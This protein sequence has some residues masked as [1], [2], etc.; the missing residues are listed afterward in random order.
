M[1]EKR[2]KAKRLIKALY[3]IDEAYYVSEKKKR[4]S[5]AEL[6]ILYALD[7]DLPH[8]QNEISK[9]WLISKSTINTITKKW[10]A[11]EILKL[12]PIENKRREMHIVLTEKGKEYA[13]KLLPFI[14]KA[15]DYALNK[16]L[17]KYGESFIEVLEYYGKNLKE[18]FEEELRKWIY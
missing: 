9:E 18:G 7:D 1:D 15:E 11:Q 12:I 10:E 14:Y 2:L 17:E 3:N 6:C 16:T 8:S 4:L 13:Q 5:D